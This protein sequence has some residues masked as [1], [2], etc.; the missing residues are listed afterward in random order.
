[1]NLPQ[2]SEFPSGQDRKEMLESNAKNREL[3]GSLGVEGLRKEY[4]WLD[5]GIDEPG[6]G[7]SF[8]KT[9]RRVLPDGEYSLR[10]YI[11]KALAPKRGQAIWIEYGGPG[12]SAS[13]EFTSGFFKQSIGVTLIDHLQDR[14]IDGEPVENPSAKKINHSIIEGDILSPETYDL[15]D[16]KLGG[17][18][19]DLIIER[20]A[21]GLKMMP[22]DPY[23]LGGI[24]N[25][26]YKQLGEGGLMFVQV[27]ASFYDILIKWAKL[28]KSDEY[29]DKFLFKHALGVRDNDPF[30]QAS[31][32]IQKLPG[33]PGELPML[34]PREIRSSNYYPNEPLS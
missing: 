29:K 12:L 17:Q 11:E 32:R 13:R 23:F 24:L 20:M 34:D 8:L 9:F 14:S 6:I 10:D 3:F 28:M 31:F 21:K 19:V 25:E 1:M 7:E 16:K 22:P 18:K 30:T 27:P 2:E 33:A 15:I 4:T 5:S 26:W